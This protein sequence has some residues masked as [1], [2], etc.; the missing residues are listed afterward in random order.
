[1]QLQPFGPR[2]AKKRHLG[3]QNGPGSLGPEKTVKTA[4]LENK[5]FES[6]GQVGSHRCP[7]GSILPP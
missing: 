7:P 1:M 5:C 3:P 4:K 2:I 6:G